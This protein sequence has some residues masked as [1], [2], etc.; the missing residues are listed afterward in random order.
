MKTKK[1]LKV[2]YKQMKPLM[3]VYQIKNQKN[4]RMLIEGSTDINAKFN[5]HRMELNFG[6]HRLKALQKDWK[7]FGEENF[8][9]EVIS[10]LET[11]DELNV[12]YKE[13]VKILEQMTIEELDIDP[14]NR[15]N[16]DIFHIKKSL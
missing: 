13:E 10:E 4:N 5:R 6:N 9:F 16:Y 8:S 11:K 2:A 3:G 1:E 12:D 7:E 15:Y 14:S